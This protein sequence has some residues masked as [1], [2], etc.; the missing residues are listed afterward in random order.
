MKVTKL[1]TLAKNILNEASYRDQMRPDT[2]KV[3][4]LIKPAIG[5]KI[6]DANA[7]AKAI[8]NAPGFD[9]LTAQQQ[10]VLRSALNWAL[11]F[12]QEMER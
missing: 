7:L 1:T 9:E 8:N 2:L 10:R 5:H 3:Y 11:V 12:A 6:W 4:D